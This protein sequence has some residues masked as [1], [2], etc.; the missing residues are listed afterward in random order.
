MVLNGSKW[1]RMV[2]PPIP[3]PG[4]GESLLPGGK[5]NR[6]NIL[7]MTFYDFYK[8]INQKRLL[9]GGLKKGFVAKL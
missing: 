6:T 3:I 2:S 5:Q 4:V 9:P 8:K 7:L 1:C